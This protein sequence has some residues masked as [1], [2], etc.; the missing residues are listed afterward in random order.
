M[1]DLSPK[2]ASFG[3]PRKVELPVW[4]VEELSDILAEIIVEDF[5][6]DGKKLVGSPPRTNRKIL[7]ESLGT[8]QTDLLDSA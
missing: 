3:S 6:Q 5:Q 8:N 4:L 1:K 2:E 7:G